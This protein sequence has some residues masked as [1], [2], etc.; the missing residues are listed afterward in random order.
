MI[1]FIKA[2]IPG[3]AKWLWGKRVIVGTIISIGA[4]SFFVWLA[5]ERGQERD[6]LKLT[7]E[8][9]ENVVK[10]MRAWHDDTV[11]SLE[12]KVEDAKSRNEFEV[13]NALE[14]AKDRVDGDGPVSPVLMRGMERLQQRQAAYR[15]NNTR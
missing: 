14:L 10:D 2:F 3:W 5:H 7:V 9:Y 8:G 13:D 1:E 12:R 15:N 4:L 6:E 11:A